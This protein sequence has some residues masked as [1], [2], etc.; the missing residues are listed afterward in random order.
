MST[1]CCV[2]QGEFGMKSAEFRTV[3]WGD[4]ALH[5]ALRLLPLAPLRLIP[6]SKNHFRSSLSQSVA[7]ILGKLGNQK[8]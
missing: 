7:V 1:L 8:R 2:K 6:A 5:P 4:R 3:Q